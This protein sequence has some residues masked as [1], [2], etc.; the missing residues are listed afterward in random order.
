MPNTGDWSTWNTVTSNPF[1]LTAGTHVMRIVIDSNLNGMNAAGNFD[2]FNVTPVIQPNPINWVLA[3]PSPVKRFE[4]Y[5][6]AY[7]GKLFTFGGYN[8]LINPYAVNSDGSVYDVATNTWSSLGQIP[9]APTHAGLAMD[10]TNGI[11][12]FVGGLMGSYPGVATTQV[13]SYDLNA[14]TWTPMPSLPIPLAAGDAVLIGN[15]LHYFAGIGSA[16]RDVDLNVHYVLTLGDTTWHTAAAFPTARDHVTAVPLNGLIYVFGGEIG[17]DTFHKQQTECD[18]Y[19]PT[20]DTW[21]QIADMP[22]SKSHAESS[23]FIWDGKIIIAGGQVD[24][25]GATNTIEEYDPATNTWAILG[26]LPGV[27]EGTMLQLIGNQL[28]LTNGYDGANMNT[29]TWIAD[30]PE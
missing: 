10:S 5:A 6:R 8:S 17:H 26:N 7:D 11:L 19:D 24:D 23:T 21:S 28:V 25:Y 13:W 12:Y 14:N 9:V 27:L 29:Q 15:Q 16:S 1:Q 2:V 4:G 3:A 20:T 30:W 18:V 22:L